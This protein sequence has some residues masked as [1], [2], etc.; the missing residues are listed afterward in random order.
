MLRWSTCN[1]VC[2]ELIVVRGEGVGPL[3][4]SRVNTEC[5]TLWRQQLR[6][7]SVPGRSEWAIQAPNGDTE[8]GPT[9]V[10]M[11]IPE[12][13]SS[14]VPTKSRF[15]IM[16]TSQLCNVHSCR[17]LRTTAGDTMAKLGMPKTMR[18]GDAPVLH[19]S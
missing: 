18:D 9:A 19:C 11:L 16:E 10:N 17:P 5:W 1:Y 4:S 12:C 13:E 15:A 6:N 2:H 7:S 14:A 8:L 3:M